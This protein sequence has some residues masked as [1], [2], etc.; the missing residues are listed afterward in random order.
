[1]AQSIVNSVSTN[2]PMF[3]KYI[4]LYFYGVS[5]DPKNPD[6]AIITPKASNTIDST[7]MN[8]KPEISIQGKFIPTTGAQGLQVRITNFETP[9]PIWQYG[10]LN[11]SLQHLHKLVVEVGYKSDPTLTIRFEGMIMTGTEEK[12]G[13]DSVTVLTLLL[14][15]FESYN[16]YPIASVNYG[17]GATVSDVINMLL[18]KLK[19]QNRYFDYKAVDGSTDKALSQALLGIGFNARGTVKDIVNE[20]HDRY[21]ID[22]TFQGNSCRVLRKGQYFAQ[23]VFD[24]K[25]VTS[26]SRAAEQYIIHGPWIP[27]ILPGDTIRVNP[28]TAKQNLGGQVAPPSVL[29]QVNTIE[30]DFSSTGKT[31]S[32]TIWSIN[33]DGSV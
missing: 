11:S 13:P 26:I 32:M 6:F 24:I 1:M 3:D 29:Q 15:D 17:P 25:Y 23:N 9:F 19:S 33:L 31:N 2:I 4:D 5:T 27:K 20:L 22:I 12:P 28:T 16:N 7:T 18:A 21:N 14:A 10:S 8:R 30:F